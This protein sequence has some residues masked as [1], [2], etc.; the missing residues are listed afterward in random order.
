MPESNSTAKIDLWFLCEWMSRTSYKAC[1]Y[2]RNIAWSKSVL[3]RIFI[4]ENQPKMSV[5]VM[6]GK[7]ACESDGRP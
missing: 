7:S 4:F 5:R 6:I 3:Q 1:Y 2:D